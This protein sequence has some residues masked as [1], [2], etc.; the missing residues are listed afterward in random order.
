MELSRRAP[1][2]ILPMLLLAGLCLGACG[3]GGGDTSA[4]GTPSPNQQP[5][6]QRSW[7]NSFSKAISRLQIPMLTTALDLVSRFPA[8]LLLSG[9]HRREV[10]RLV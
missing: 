5:T 7:L 8:I 10:V 6:N 3:G 9:H 1:F 4:A 2:T